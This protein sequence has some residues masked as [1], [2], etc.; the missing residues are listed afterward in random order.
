MTEPLGQGLANVVRL[1]T[2]I[3]QIGASFIN[4]VVPALREAKAS[5]EKPT[6][7]NVR[8]I[9]GVGSAMADQAVSHRAPFKFNDV[10]EMKSVYGFDLDEPTRGATLLR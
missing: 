9:I 3:E 4:G 2:A 8:D 6:L 10:Q 7:V 5:K 1:A